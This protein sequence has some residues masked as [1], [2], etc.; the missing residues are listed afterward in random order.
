[1]ISADLAVDWVANNLYWVDSAWARIEV[2]GLYTMS[3]A[4]ILQTGAN[5]NPTAI[6]VDP[7]SRSAYIAH[8]NM[9]LY[10]T[11][12]KHHRFMFWTDFGQT[13]QIE[14]AFLD[15][16]DRRV[17]HDTDLLQ[18]VGITVD[19]VDG[20]VYWSDVGLDRIEFSELDGSR[21][22]AVETES[23]GLYHP[24]ALTVAD[25]ILFW[26]D[27]ETN[28]VYATHKEHGANDALGYF[29]VVAT[30]AS[31]PYGIEALLQSRQP[32]GEWMS[33]WVCILTDRLFSLTQQVTHAQQQIAATFVC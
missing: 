5:T 17:L 19:Y 30:F 23:T 3:R 24:F 32:T 1:M 10:D 22:M 25:D 33:T 13:A 27:W 29:A 15:G 28:T 20:R 11:V 7:V 31:T 4:E 12:S 8:H 21:R 6:A 18:P 16:N 9:W 14:R 26:T 2:L